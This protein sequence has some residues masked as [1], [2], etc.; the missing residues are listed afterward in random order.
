MG[1]E[2]ESDSSCASMHTQ[3]HSYTHSHTY[4]HI[5]TCLCIHIPTLSH[6]DTH[7]HT[8]FYIHIHTYILIYTHSYTFTQTHSH[9]H[10]HTHTYLYIH[11]HLHTHILYTH[12][13]THSH[14]YTYAHSHIFTHTHTLKLSVPQCSV[15]PPLLWCRTEGTWYCLWPCVACVLMD[16]KAVLLSDSKLG[17][18]VIS[19]LVLL[20]FIL[21]NWFTHQMCKLCSRRREACEGKKVGATGRLSWNKVWCNFDEHHPSPAYTDHQNLLQAVVT[22]PQKGYAK[23]DPNI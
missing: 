7:S 20:P 11:I 5:H 8:C 3:S 13:Y 16:S 17:L 21:C 15:H 14:T 2:W 6:T 4:S 9:I 19:L 22:D 1:T 18:P 12:L 10:S 23:W